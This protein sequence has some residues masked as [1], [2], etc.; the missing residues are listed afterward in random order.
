MKDNIKKEKKLE[1]IDE[2]KAPNMNLDIDMMIQNATQLV[3]NRYEAEL[4]K[5]KRFHHK[6]MQTLINGGKAFYKP[7]L[8]A[9]LSRRYKDIYIV[10]NHKMPVY[11]HRSNCETKGE[12]VNWGI[13]AITTD[14][15]SA[16]GYADSYFEEWQGHSDYTSVKILH[17]QV[18][19]RS[20]QGALV[21]DVTLALKDWNPDKRKMVK[22][23][24]EGQ[25]ADSQIINSLVKNRPKYE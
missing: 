12:G 3:T 1:I 16:L 17:L 11:C 25:T 4:K 18:D 6:E 15:E 22:S 9:R 13:E 21:D 8:W 7:S 10:Y 23:K 14:L 19:R 20:R 2:Q 5:Q 24:L